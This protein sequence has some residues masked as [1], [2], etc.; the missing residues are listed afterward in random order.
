MSDKITIGHYAS[1]AKEPPVWNI[2][3]AHIEYD[4][5]KYFKCHPWIPV[6][7]RLPEES[8]D[9][10]SV[11]VL[12]FCGEGAM[13]GYYDYRYKGWRSRGFNIANAS[14]WMPLPEPPKI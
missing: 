13:V 4:G 2:K 11:P 9:R 5:V 12:L 8:T 14:H 3:D 6:S 10:L 1:H 7:E